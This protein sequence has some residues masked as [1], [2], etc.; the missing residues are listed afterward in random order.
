MLLDLIGT[1]VV[2]NLYKDTEIIKIQISGSTDPG[3]TEYPN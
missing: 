2:S 3:L 1:G